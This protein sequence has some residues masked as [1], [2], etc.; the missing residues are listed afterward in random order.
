MTK[1]VEKP[2]DSFFGDANGATYFFS[3]EA[4]DEILNLAILALKQNSVSEKSIT[5][6]SSKIPILLITSLLIKK[7]L[8]TESISK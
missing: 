8:P 6:F 1:Y 4:I 5:Y 3:R 7:Q 2:K